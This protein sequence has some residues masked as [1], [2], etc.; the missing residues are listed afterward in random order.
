MNRIPASTLETSLPVWVIGGWGITMLLIAI[1]IGAPVAEA[2]HY[3][4]TEHQALVHR[5]ATSIGT[6]N[7]ADDENWCP[8]SHTS[9]ML[10]STL[11]TVVEDAL[12]NSSPRWRN[13]SNGLV[14]YASG[15]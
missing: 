15:L 13:V 12:Q 2:T 10:P 11:G 7:S 4:G 3:S 6:W 9:Y 8:E 14:E 5:G 1:M